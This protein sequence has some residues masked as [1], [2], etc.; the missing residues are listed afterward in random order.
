MN[1]LPFLKFLIEED[2]ALLDQDMVLE[3]VRHKD[4]T[5]ELLDIIHGETWMRSLSKGEDRRKS[6][7]LVCEIV[8]KKQTPDSLIEKIYKD[9]MVDEEIHQDILVAMAMKESTPPHILTKLAR[10]SLAAIRRRVINNKYATEE[11]VLY[12]LNDP[13]EDI[14]C[15]AN[16]HPNADFTYVIQNRDKNNIK[17]KKTKKRMRKFLDNYLTIKDYLNRASKNDVLNR[18]RAKR[19]K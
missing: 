10:S 19:E 3:I 8:D 14:S 9:C 15:I 17:D 6:I 16:G 12:L 1:E 4:I 13:Y 7:Q 18:L 5:P 11:A 2:M